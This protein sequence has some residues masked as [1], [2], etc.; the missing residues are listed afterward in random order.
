MQ[1]FEDA[2]EQMLWPEKREQGPGARRQGAGHHRPH[3]G[4]QLRS[5]SRSASCPSCW[6]TLLEPFRDS[7]RGSSTSAAT[8]RSARSRR[9]C[10][11]ACSPISTCGP[12]SMGLATGVGTT[13]SSL[14]L[15]DPAR[16]ATCAR[17]PEDASDEERAQDV[18]RPGRADARAQQVPGLRGQSRPLFRHRPEF[19]EEPG[20]SDDAKARPDRVPED[21]LSRQTPM[22]PQASDGD[23]DYVVV[24]SG[25]GGGTR[26]GPPGR[27]RLQASL[28]LEAGG[29]P[30]RSRAARGMGDANRLPDDYDVPAFHAFAYGEPGDALGLLRPPLCRR[31]AAGARPEVPDGR[32]TASSIRAPARSAAAPRT[33]R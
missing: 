22:P 33:T 15:A 5:P 18:R 28:L 16:S 13:P 19:A 20:L 14:R 7:L 31:G 32:A 27:G 25:A 11:S 17:M 6:S 26:G 24:G 3:D 30:R 21:V 10:R 23:F 1:A 2:I 29:D 8:S 4:A 12:T 9:A